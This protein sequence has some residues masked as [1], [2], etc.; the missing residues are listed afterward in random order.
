MARNAFQLIDDI[1]AS[2]SELKGVLAPLAALTGKTAAAPRQTRSPRKSTRTRAVRPARSQRTRRKK[3]SRAVAA[4]RV[5]Q[6]Q[7][8]AAV[9]PL[10]KADRLKVSAVQ[11]KKG[12]RPAIA[13]AHTLKK[14]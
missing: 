10:T 1:T 3:V 12:H 2:L 14:K 6:G 4:K 13:Y 9:R 5:L 8:M 11:K 7:Y